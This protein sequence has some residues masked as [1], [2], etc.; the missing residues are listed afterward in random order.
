MS[1]ACLILLSVLMW[2]THGTLALAFD[3]EKV[4][5]KGVS[6][7]ETTTYGKGIGQWR[8]DVPLPQNNTP[9]YTLRFQDDK[10]AATSRSP[11]GVLPAEQ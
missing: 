1:R 6:M 3:P 5:E 10:S 2:S 9:I 8:L 7:R 11:I 4:Q